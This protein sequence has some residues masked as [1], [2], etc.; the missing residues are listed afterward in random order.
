M[1]AASRQNGMWFCD[2]IV[3]PV[4]IVYVCSVLFQTSAHVSFENDYVVKYITENIG[5]Q[6]ARIG[7]QCRIFVI[8]QITL[9]QLETLELLVHVAIDIQQHFNEESNTLED[10][11]KGN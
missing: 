9:I 8:W 2:M 11:A 6:D 3:K 10:I 4:R 5:S 7:K 1:A